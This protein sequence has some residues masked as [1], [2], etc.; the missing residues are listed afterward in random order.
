MR[1]LRHIGAM[2]RIQGFIAPTFTPLTAEGDLQLDRVAAYARHLEE[3]R[4]PNIF[5]G[6][7]SSEFSSFPIKERKQINA[8][9]IRQGRAHLSGH[10]IVHVGATALADV[11]ELARHAVQEG[12][13]AIACTAPFYEVRRGLNDF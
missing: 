4:V 1:V 5:V 6:G 2:L 7:T 8:E 11:Q 9:W 13:H 10:V 12:A 3:H